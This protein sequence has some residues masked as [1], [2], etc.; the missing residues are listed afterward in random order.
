MENAYLMR[1]VKKIVMYSFK[2]HVI[3][4]ENID[5]KRRKKYN[6]QEIINKGENNNDKS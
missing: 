1:K 5:I 3:T 4:R 6:K 2:S